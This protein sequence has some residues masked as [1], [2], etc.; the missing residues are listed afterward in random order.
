L[1]IRL[2]VIRGPRAGRWLCRA[3]DGLACV[4]LPG[5]GASQISAWGRVP[6]LLANAVGLAPRPRP[7]CGGVLVTGRGT[8]DRLFDS[9]VA[10]GHL[11]GDETIEAVRAVFAP[12]ELPA[13]WVHALARL[14]GGAITQWKVQ[15]VVSGGTVLDTLEIVDGDASGL[16]SLTDHSPESFADEIDDVD[17][18]TVDGEND[19]GADC[20]REALVALAPT[21]PTAVWAWL[22]RLAG[23]S[24]E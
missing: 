5:I 1:E 24:V 9:C 11:P 19:A 22:S 3:E 15:I 8:L 18:R 17:I 2:D 21:T 14:A 13:G 16:W 7:R 4:K 6:G 23:A 12:T 20:G 10:A